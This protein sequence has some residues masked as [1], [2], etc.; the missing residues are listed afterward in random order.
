M[1]DKMNYGRASEAL[2]IYRSAM[3]T[4]IAD[5]LERENAGAG[6]WFGNLVL[7]NLPDYLREDLERQLASAN[8]E[9]ETVNSNGEYPED[10]HF[11]E[12]RH[13]PH[14]VRE[15]WDGFRHSLKDRSDVLN[16]LRKLKKYRDKRV[17]HNSRQLSDDQVTEIISACLSVVERF[18]ANSAC[19]LTELLNPPAFLPVSDSKFSARED[20]SEM[21][22][23]SAVWTSVEQIEHE[24]QTS[25]ERVEQ[26]IAHFLWAG[27]AMD[28][29]ELLERTL[30]TLGTY[31]EVDSDEITA[32]LHGIRFGEIFQ[33]LVAQAMPFVELD[34][35]VAG[36][37]SG[38]VHYSLPGSRLER[39]VIEYELRER[40]N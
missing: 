13:Y 19:Q 18:D 22:D 21:D 31:V 15:N 39:L 8:A 32:E 20:L 2:R 11:L 24:R 25:W 12:E 16:L 33:D 27:E 17:A 7:A 6:D 37:H 4:F 28:Q 40:V 38:S 26:L 35:T 10:K 5:T 36:A 23:Q 9:R 30:N 1:I 3:Q 34:E 29:A 14:I